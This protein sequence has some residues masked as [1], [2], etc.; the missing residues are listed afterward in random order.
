MTHTLNTTPQSGLTKSPI[1]FFGTEAFSLASLQALID[2]DFPIAAVVTKQDSRKG[3]GRHLVPPEVK[4]LAE[5][6]GIPVWQPHKLDEIIDDITA[7][8]SPVGVLVSFGKI[9]PQRIIDLFSPGIINVHPSKLPLYRGPSPIESAILNGD[10]ETGV[11]IM[12]LCAAMDAGP[13][14]HFTPYALDGTETQQRLYD[15]LASFGAQQLVRVLPSILDGSRTPIAQDDAQATY[16]SLLQKSDGVI[17]WTKPALQI[18]REI[19]AY[20]VWPQSRTTLGE[21]D[22]I[23]T[24]ATAVWPT[25]PLDSAIEIIYDQDVKALFVSAKDSLLE[26]DRIK[27]VGKKE[28]PIQ[29]FLTGYKD[30]LSELL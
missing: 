29:A 12:Q 6:H 2:A 23:I 11:S 1:V 20:N 24:A 5:A 13:V 3:R 19:R 21:V 4:V 26:I 8:D 22:V 27:P 14:Y 7:L 15:T 9:I 30:K 25:G 18:E 16:C 17:D 10:A 28:M